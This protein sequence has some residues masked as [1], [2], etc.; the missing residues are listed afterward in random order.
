MNSE[1]RNSAPDDGGLSKSQ[2][3]WL[4]LA[5]F[6]V[7]G[8]FTFVIGEKSSY[9]PLYQLVCALANTVLLV[10]WFVLDAA[11]HNFRLTTTWIWCFVLIFIF[12]ALFYF[13]KTRGARMWRPLLGAV[14]TFFA[15]VFSM[16]LGHSIAQLLKL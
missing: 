8:W 13:Y 12:T 4:L 6:F 2:T 9:F 7:E 14:G 5:L 1:L 11:Q 10:R 3:L 16:G 15:G